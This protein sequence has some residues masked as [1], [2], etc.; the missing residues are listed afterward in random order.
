M[1]KKFYNPF[2]G[3]TIFDW[4]LWLGSIIG[5]LLSFFLC[6]NTQYLYLVGA[7]LG[8][9][10]L[11][12]LAKGNVLGQVL[13]VVFSGFYGYVSYTFAYY[14][15][16]ITY[17]GLTAPMAICAVIAWLKNPYEQAGKQTEVKVN[18]ISR[19]EHA[20][21]LGGGLLIT[22]SFYFILGAFDTPNLIV[23]TLSVLTSF[24]AVYYTARRSPLYALW[25]AANDVV[26]ILLWSFAS[27]ENLEYL[28]MVVCFAVFLLNDL[29]GF[30]Q[31]QRMK[32]RQAKE[33]PLE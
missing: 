28:C 9:T 17:L 23:S 6:R 8:V 29:Y 3:F 19:R 14:G 33:P 12:F 24:L 30:I 1:K 13:S 7:L 26:L 20:L 4:C 2:R 18:K 5:V 31:W 27:A 11:I 16:M 25:Y 10:A 22:L 15:E 21:A 32:K